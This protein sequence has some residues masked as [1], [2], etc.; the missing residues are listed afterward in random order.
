M[1]RFLFTFLY[2]YINTSYI[3]IPLQINFETNA[4]LVIVLNKTNDNRIHFK[5]RHKKI[6]AFKSLGYTQEERGEMKIPQNR[7]TRPAQNSM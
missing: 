7:D 4:Y 6:Q 1:V 3:E 5:G 2:A